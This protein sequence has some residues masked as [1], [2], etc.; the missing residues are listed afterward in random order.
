M[1][2]GAV[3]EAGA[4][5]VPSLTIAN[6]IATIGFRRPAFHNRIEPADLRAL[7]ALFKQIDADPTLRVAVLRATGRS[8]SSGF[9][10][11][12]IGGQAFGD[13]SGF[14]AI[15]DQLEGLRVPTIC[16]LNGS[17]YGGST[18]LALACDFRIGVTGMVMMMP[19][20]KI[21]LHYY[22]SGM[23]RYVSRLGLNSAKRLFL[24]GDKLAADELLQIGFL[25]ELVTAERLDTR[26]AELAAQLAT[27]AP[28]AVQGMKS[29]LNAIAR[30][31][32]DDA[33][34]GV[35]ARELYR[36]EDLREGKAAWLEKRRPSFT[37]R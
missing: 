8:F 35:R 1:S 3:R 16:G 32:A 19:A 26:V 29:A 37:G 9:H 7:A 18:D 2:D 24:T 25:T 6:G 13:E 17:V 34:I 12:E 21:G 23:R 36:S 31:D 11:G 10:I 27:N 15:V 30:G 28:L 5:G 22:P 20:A 33:A 4:E 14:A